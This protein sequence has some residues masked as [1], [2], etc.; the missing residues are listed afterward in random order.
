MNGHEPSRRFSPGEVEIEIEIEWARR[1]IAA[2]Q[3]RH[4]AAAALDGRVIDQPVS[5]R[6]QGIL[7]EVRAPSRAGVAVGRVPPANERSCALLEPLRRLDC[8][9][10]AQV[11]M[12]RPASVAD[13]R[14]C[15]R[16][17]FGPV[18]STLLR[19]RRVI[20]RE[21]KMNHD[22]VLPTFRLD[23]GT[24]IAQAHPQT[25]SP[26]TVDSP[27]LEV[28]TDLTQVKAATINPATSLRQAEQMMVYQGVRM[29]FV[30]TDM[31]SIEGLITATDLKGEKQMR[32]VHERNVHYDDLC[33]ADVMTGLSMLDA[34]DYDRMGTATV[35][36][37]IATLR[38]FGRNHLLVVQGAAPRTPRRVR[39]VISRAQIERQLG[40]AID[41][42][43]IASTFSEIERALF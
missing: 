16:G 36:N 41:I 10:A 23:G 40:K 31:P 20:E 15:D 38:R 22:A 5:L 42:T 25:P 11:C 27:A 35:G 26:V 9:L 24:A 39:G 12:V 33:V 18:R 28:M 43:P 6:A 3:A 2:A 29:L 37:V 34:I 17:R 7:R 13:L 19:R 1:V 32:T 8:R 4:G 14:Y 30:V 21:L